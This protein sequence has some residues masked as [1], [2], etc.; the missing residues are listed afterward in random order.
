MS[1]LNCFDPGRPLVFVHIPKTSGT[2]LNDALFAACA[3]GRTMMAWDL[4][5]FGDFTDFDS[6]D[7][8]IPAYTYRSPADLPDG[9]EVF[10]GHIAYSSYQE[11][12]GHAQFI[13]VLREPICRLLSLWLFWRSRPDDALIAWGTWAHRVKH[14]RRP[15]AHFL[16][17]PDIACQTDN[18][19]LRMLL[20]P[21][22]LIP[23]DGFI[24]PE[25]DAELLALA[26]ERLDGFSF[27]GIL[28]HEFHRQLS[29]WLGRPL[30]AKKLNETPA[31]PADLRTVLH[32]ELTPEAHRLLADR[33]RLDQ[34][35][36]A[37][38]ALRHLDAADVSALR[39]SVLIKA[40]A[41]FA[42]LT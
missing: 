35:L 40:A 19:A 26:R 27:V 20:W 31:M 23:V 11:K 34:Q 12:Y 37:S 13:T 25:H 9:I 15:L 22:P 7:P 10:T 14:A 21:H 41:R 18:V 6:M 8:G 30:Q 28:E 17:S 4:C 2:T 29:A 5:I 38:T 16:S 39:E 1:E 3:S 24:H 36:W 32:E 33:S 42:T